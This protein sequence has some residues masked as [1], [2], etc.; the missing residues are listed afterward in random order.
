MLDQHSGTLRAPSGAA[1]PGEPAFDLLPATEELLREASRL[2]IPVRI[3]VAED[4]DGDPINELEALVSEAE[5]VAGIDGLKPRDRPGILVAAD[6]VVRA[7]AAGLGWT[8]VPHPALAVA[9]ARGEQ[10]VFA[11]LSGDRGAIAAVTGLVPYWLEEPSDGPSRALAA[12]PRREELLR[13]AERA[14]LDDL[15][16]RAVGG[17]ELGGRRRSPR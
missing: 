11:R 14:L 16:Q 13:D 12:L 8:A 17:G 4:L 1:D 9:A 15:E 3:V 5:I 7:R 6:R 10:L 2:Q